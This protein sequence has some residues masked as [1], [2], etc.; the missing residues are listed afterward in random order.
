M[1]CFDLHLCI[2]SVF[3]H[4]IERLSVYIKQITLVEEYTPSF[5]ENSRLQT[6]PRLNVCDIYLCERISDDPRLEIK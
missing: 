4:F 1:A 5:R 2:A 6:D 3:M